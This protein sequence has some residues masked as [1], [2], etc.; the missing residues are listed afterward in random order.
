MAETEARGDGNGRDHVGGIEQADVE[1]VAHVRPGHLAHQFDVEAFCRGKALVDRDD[2]GGGVAERN[3]SDA[4][5]FV[6]HLNS[7][8]AVIDRLRHLG[9]LL[10]LVHR[11]LAQQ[12]VGGFFAEVFCF[13]QY[14]L[15]A[16]DHLALFERRARAVEFVLQAREGVEARDA[17]IEDVLHA[18][19]AQSADD[20]G[21]D[22]GVDRGLDRGR[23]ALVDEHG[24]RALDGAA[25][26]EHLLEH[27]A[28]RI[29]QVDQDD[30]G[31]DGVDAGQQVRHLADPHHMDMAGL[32]QALLQDGRA[33]RILIDDDDL[34]GGV[35][36]TAEQSSSTVP[37]PIRER[38]SRIINAIGT[39]HGRKGK[40]R[41]ANRLPDDGAARS[42][43]VQCADGLTLVG[44]GTFFAPAAATGLVCHVATADR[45]S[46][47]EI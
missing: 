6:A 8:A 28:A 33:D 32:A 30:V 29:L 7:S 21:G 3:E 42:Q 10:V 43:F 34:E 39:R 18:L 44:V 47:S 4:Q 22:P 23:V 16:I 36:N 15:G 31:V 20:V 17:E 12:R 41:A 5:A 9:D 13:H 37:T 26:L 46:G 2:R 11:G 38:N 1:L 45:G 25:D 40:F 14:A 24:D 19:L 35:H 27:V